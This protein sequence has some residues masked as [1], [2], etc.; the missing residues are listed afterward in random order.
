M[1]RE[2]VPGMTRGIDRDQ[3]PMV[4]RQYVAIMKRPVDTFERRRAPYLQPELVGECK[5]GRSVVAVPVREDDLYLVG[6]LNRIGQGPHVLLTLG[7]GVD[8]RDASEA[9]EIAPGSVECERARVSRVQ[10]T[11]MLA[12]RAS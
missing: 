9:D 4:G 7:T 5:G 10:E 8:D 11:G 12:Q 2:V 6:V 1:E 3:V